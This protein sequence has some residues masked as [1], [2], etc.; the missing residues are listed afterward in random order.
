MH[1]IERKKELKNKN[2]DDNNRNFTELV[3]RSNIVSAISDD[4]AFAIFRTIALGNGVYNSDILISKTKLT[5]IQYYSRLAD[6]IKAGLVKRKNGK[7]FL[8]SLGKIVYNNQHI[9]ESALANHW[10]LKAI[11]SFEDLNELSKEE[12]RLFIDTII[13][14]DYIKE[15]ITK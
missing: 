1:L 15:I 11:D 4:K 10:R 9:I 8:T 2:D 12:R 7:Y 5:R 14:D 3:S 13:D 6:F